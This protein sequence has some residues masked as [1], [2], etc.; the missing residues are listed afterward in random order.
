[1]WTRAAPCTGK[2]WTPDHIVPLLRQQGNNATPIYLPADP[3][4]VPTAL[5]ALQI[6]RWRV[7][8]YS[9]LVSFQNSDEHEQTV[10]EG[11]IEVDIAEASVLSEQMAS[12]TRDAELSA[13]P[14]AS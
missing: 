2:I 7:T 13:S 1:M 11:R 8:A 9:Q 10:E 14:S 6:H 4:P 12:I 3:E 5:L